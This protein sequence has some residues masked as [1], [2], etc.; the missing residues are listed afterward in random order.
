MLYISSDRGS[1][2]GAWNDMEI[3]AYLATGQPDFLP[4]ERDHD[5]MIYIVV[6]RIAGR[7]VLES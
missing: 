2:I 6:S 3:A 7:D 5:G 1:G 4:H